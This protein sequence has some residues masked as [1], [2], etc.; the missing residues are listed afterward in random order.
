MMLR[1]NHV[2]APTNLA[3]V[4]Q[5]MQAA[6]DQAEVVSAVMGAD[7]GERHLRRRLPGHRQTGQSTTPAWT[8]VRKRH[9]R[10]E[11]KAHAG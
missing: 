5:T 9:T 10:D 2:I 8:C 11:L 4:R 6:I 7:P 1:P 3:A